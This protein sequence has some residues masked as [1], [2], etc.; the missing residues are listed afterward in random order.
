[1]AAR[2]RAGPFAGR[3]ARQGAAV[4]R[5]RAARGGRGAAN[6]SANSRDGLH[7]A[8]VATDDPTV[9][10]QVEQQLRLWA[11]TRVDEAWLAR[12][13]R[14]YLPPTF[15]P[16]APREVRLPAPTDTVWVSE[17][18]GEP[19]DGPE[20]AARAHEDLVAGNADPYLEVSD[21]TLHESDDGRV[22]P[23]HWAV[24]VDAT[25]GPEPN[26]N[27]TAHAPAR[28][29]AVT[30]VPGHL[31]VAHLVSDRRLRPL[32]W[33]AVRAVLRSVGAAHS[34]DDP[35]PPGPAAGAVARLWAVQ[36]DAARLSRTTDASPAG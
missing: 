33:A 10:A 23:D 22:L 14:L 31:P 30:V 35:L 20:E 1:M 3:P 6:A 9:V 27:A 34:W 19:V 28:V 5:R 21:W 24:L 18:A 4:P 29:A 16:H 2:R 17:V 7:E 15:R 8:A 32:R 11:G 26:G 25:D 13:R 12:A 36:S